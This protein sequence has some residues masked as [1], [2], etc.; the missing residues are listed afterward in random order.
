MTPK[1]KMIQASVKRGGAVFPVVARG[2]NPAVKTG[3]K[4]ASN[5]WNKIKQW[6]SAHPNAN[7]GIATGAASNIIV[8]DLDEFT[9]LSPE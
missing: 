9:P 5:D 7:Y 6:F 4:A 3:V 1:L 8:V 2:K